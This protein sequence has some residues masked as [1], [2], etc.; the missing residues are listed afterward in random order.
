MIAL[1]LVRIVGVCLVQYSATSIWMLYVLV[2]EEDYTN[3]GANGQ[4]YT[5]T[6]VVTMGQIFTLYREIP[7]AQRIEKRYLLLMTISCPTRDH[8][9]NKGMAR[10]HKTPKSEVW[11]RGMYMVVHSKINDTRIL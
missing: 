4:K 10:G 3:N 9:R 8:H 11:Y 2:G 7:R 5:T 6:A 1:N